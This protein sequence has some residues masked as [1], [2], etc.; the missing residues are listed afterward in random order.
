M[1]YTEGEVGGSTSKE[2]GSAGIGINWLHL[3]RSYQGKL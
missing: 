2:R 1:G 3:I